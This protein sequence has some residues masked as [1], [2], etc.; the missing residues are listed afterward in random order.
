MP[1]R[2]RIDPQQ[3][4]VLYTVQHLTMEEI[5][6]LVGRSRSRIAQIL[7]QAGTKAEQGTWVNRSCAYCGEAIKVRRGLARKNI[8]SYCHADHYYASRENPNY[9]RCRTGQRLARAIV[10]QQ[11]RLLPGHVVHHKDGD[12]RNN[13]KANLR[14]FA[15]QSDHMAHHHGKQ[16][17]APL[18]D[19]A[20]P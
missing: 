6:L 10:A 8:A 19:G 20:E 5:G 16:A 2:N 1:A 14:V 18:W 12:N 4:V 3:V 15:S 11:F 9:Y 17:V 7:K 13:D